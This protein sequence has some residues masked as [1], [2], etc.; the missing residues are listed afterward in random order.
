MAISITKVNITREFNDV[1]TS[2][3]IETVL[4]DIQISDSYGTVSIPY[5][6]LGDLLEAIQAFQGD[7]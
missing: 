5:H 2:I 1:T 4:N 6:M 3:N 7:Y